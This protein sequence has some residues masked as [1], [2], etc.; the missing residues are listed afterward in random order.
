[1]ERERQ[2]PIRAVCQ[3]YSHR[4]PKVQEEGRL[5][6]IRHEE[7]G[8]ADSTLFGRCVPAAVER[9]VEPQRSA[10]RCV[11][12]SMGSPVCRPERAEGHQGGGHFSGSARCSQSTRAGAGTRH[13]QPE[14]LGH[15]AGPSEGWVLG[16]VGA[17]RVDRRSQD[18]G[19][20]LYVG[21]DQCLAGDLRR[22]W[23]RLGGCCNAS[24]AFS[25]YYATM[26]KAVTLTL[27]SA[28]RVSPFAQ[29]VQRCQGWLHKF[30][31]RAEFDSNSS[32]STGAKFTSPSHVFPILRRLQFLWPIMWSAV[33]QRW[34]SRSVFQQPCSCLLGRGPGE[35]SVVTPGWPLRI[36][37]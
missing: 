19:E 17:D 9:T 29:S 7:S 8:G 5:G 24:M 18:V 27:K 20:P 26:A 1:M 34:A 12:D 15:P 13:H 37:S 25:Q 35:S 30:R 22:T 21:S 4:W 36:P 2:G 31:R 3:P 16:K 10:P 33:F 23:Y 28:G 32:S 11:S 14:N 6:G